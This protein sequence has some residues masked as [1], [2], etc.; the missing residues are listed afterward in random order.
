MKPLR[1]KYVILLIISLS[2]FAYTMAPS[3]AAS[4][5]AKASHWIEPIK[6]EITDQFGTR[7]ANIKDLISLLL[8]ERAWW[9]P[10]A[11]P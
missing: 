3:A 8:K 4:K 5:G 7:E 6:G 10:Q 11:E 9:L 2:G 1:H